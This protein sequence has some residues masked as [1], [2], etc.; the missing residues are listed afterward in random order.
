MKSFASSPRIVAPRVILTA[1]AIA[2]VG[3]LGVIGWIWRSSVISTSPHA[4]EEYAR[5]AALPNAAPNH[6]V[7]AVETVG[8]SNLLSAQNANQAVPRKVAI[9][10]ENRAGAALNDKVPVLEDFLT[11]RITEKGFSVISREIAINA[12]K[13]YPTAEIA[14]STAKATKVEVDTPTG[15]AEAGVGVAS[16][17]AAQIS[18][19]SGMTKLDKLLSDST[20]ALR[21]AQNLGADYLLVASITTFAP[22]QIQK[23]KEL[24]TVIITHTLR[25]SYKVLEALEGGSLIG[26]VAK[27]TKSTRSTEDNQTENPD[28]VNELLDDAATQVAESA[29]KK[30]TTIASAVALPRSVEIFVSCA[31]QDL[32]QLPLLTDIR[33]LDNGNLVVTTNRISIQVVYATVKV[34][35]FARGSAPGKFSVP[36]GSHK[37]RITRAGFNDYEDDVIFS[38]GQRFEN[39]A[40]QM[41]EAGYA[42]WKDNT[43]FLFAIKTGEKM[44]D[45]LREMMGGFSQTLRQSGYRVDTKT[46]IKANIETKGKSLFDGLVVQPTLFK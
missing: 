11:S 43:T 35:G 19:T 3:S 5:P 30:I 2:V 27:A 34:D 46:D 28:I 13:T 25:V 23:N 1:I 9:F 45:G 42:R 31:M 40:L 16:A 22:P 10:V 20:S 29:G 44:T 14:A 7:A 37:M 41:S 38:E 33:I 18:V 24:N 6:L 15:S 12:L 21:L 17:S 26:D 39:V 4:Q 8:K 32:V 36:P